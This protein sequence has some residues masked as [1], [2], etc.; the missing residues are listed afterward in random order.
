MA[1]KQKLS[2]GVDIGGTSIKFGVVSK[3]GEIIEKSSLETFSEEGPDKVIEQIKKG[4]KPYIKK[5]GKQVKGIGIGSP[6]TIKLKKGIVENPPN[7]KDWES[8]ALGKAVSKDF[9]VDVHVENDAN[10]AAIGEYMFGSAKDLKNFIM[11]TLG[12]GVGG[13]IFIDKKL[14]RGESGAAGEIGHITIKHN[15]RKCNCGSY[16]CVEA[17]VGNRYLV[18]AVKQKLSRNKDSKINELLDGDM[19]KLTPELIYNALTQGD[20]FAKS[21]VIEAGENLGYGLAS[22]VNL[23]DVTNIIIGGGVAGFGQILFDS[24]EETIKQR[25]MRSFVE[26]ITVRQAELKNDAGVKGAS[27]LVFFRS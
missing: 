12:T 3:D 17:Y 13:G 5:Y 23:L 19:S 10:C 21:I 22:V 9:N 7:F 2:I 26:R 1:K 14:Y 6:G 24:V 20:E 4:V 11:V 8:V 16:G 25:V 15:G 27:A 18:E